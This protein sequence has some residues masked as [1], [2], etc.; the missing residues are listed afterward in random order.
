MN[1]I[2]DEFGNSRNDDIPVKCIQGDACD[3]I[4]HADFSFDL[5]HSNSVIEHVGRWSDMRRFAREVR[6][7]APA[8]YVQ[9]P[10]FWFPIDP[11]YYR[12]PFFHWMPESVR[13]KAHRRVKLGWPSPEPEIDDAMRLVTSSNMLDGAQFR[14]LFPDARHSF[15][16]LALLPKSMIAIRGFGA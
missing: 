1:H 7:L 6:R 16:R 8:Y 9:T 11:H 13:L 5:V 10:Y 3:M 12:M 14:T 2:V 15:E 4:D